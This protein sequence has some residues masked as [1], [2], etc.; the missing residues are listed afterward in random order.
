M[1][2][3]SSRAGSRARSETHVRTGGMHLLTS[4]HSSSSATASVSSA[5]DSAGASDSR[6]DRWSKADTLIAGAGVVAALVA[7]L[8]GLK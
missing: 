4:S 5:G 6:R 3:A 8:L 1:T 7:A 2:E